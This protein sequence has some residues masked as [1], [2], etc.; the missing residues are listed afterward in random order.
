MSCHVPA[1][2]ILTGLLFVGCGG[3]R[4]TYSEVDSFSC[5]DAERETES[6]AA[7]ARTQRAAG[8]FA[9]ASRL[10]EKAARGAADTPDAC[11]AEG[12]RCPHWADALS[13]GLMVQDRDRISAATEGFFACLERNP[14]YTPTDDERIIFAMGAAMSGRKPPFTLPASAHRLRSFIDNAV[15]ASRDDDR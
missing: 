6:F 11:G 4:K 8:D 12:P 10:F 2:L 9:R 15:A 1:L 13:A 3:A 14:G 7:S 5:V